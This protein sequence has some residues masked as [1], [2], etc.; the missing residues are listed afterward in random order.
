[1]IPRLQSILL[2]FFLCSGVLMPVS[3]Q[4]TRL[5]SADKDSLMSEELLEAQ[6][7]YIAGLREFE[8]ENY[9]K[10]LELL[11]ASYIKL[12]GNSGVNF[13]LA[14]TYYKLDEL[15]NAAYYAKQAINLEPDNPWYHLKLSDI[16]EKDGKFNLAIQ[17]QNE[18][19]TLKPGDL[20]ILA[21]LAHLHESF[22][23]LKKAN[24]VYREMLQRRPGNIQMYMRRYANFRTM[25]QMDSAVHELEKV[26]SIDPENISTLQKL[27][28][29]YLELDSIQ[30]AKGILQQAYK[31]NQQNTKTMLMLANIYLQLAEWNKAGDIINEMLVDPQVEPRNKLDVVEYL[32]QNVNQNK[33]DSTLK[34][35]T[36]RAIE[37]FTSAESGYGQA[38]LISSE[39]YMAVGDSLK[40]LE[41]LEKT[42]TVSPQNDV[43]WRR[44][45]QLLFNTGQYEKVTEIGLNADKYVPDDPFILYFVG[46]SHYLLGQHEQSTKWLKRASLVPARRP[47]KSSVYAILGDVYASQE[48]WAES[49]KAYETALSMNSDNHNALNNYAYYLAERGRDLQKALKMIE[50]A[51]QQQSDN[52]SYLDTAGWVHYKLGN[53]GEARK[54]L[55]KAVETGSA[56]AEI[57]EHL[58]DVY[59]KMERL[60]E[61]RK[62]W[63]RALKMDPSREYLRDKISNES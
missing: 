21:E 5:L 39:Y 33:A 22:G 1:M 2:V 42:V 13:A 59:L 56:S 60:E 46:A 49:D 51:L 23:N 12:P 20:D 8:L 27:S 47:F 10:A 34:S 37:N 14:D 41:A 35:V 57:F 50:T 38:H 9:D 40:A 55:R 44:Q 28:S 63:Q 3:A 18:A 16:Y 11:T 6:T 58:G 31:L 61:A 62:W 17:S 19:F 32:V 24:Q 53:Y 25:N 43:A 7:K 26:R 48:L 15:N 45:I 30:K 36:R 54:Y 29:I 52:A 4:P